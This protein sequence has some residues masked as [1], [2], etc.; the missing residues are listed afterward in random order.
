MHLRVCPKAA[1]NSPLQNLLDEDVQK[2]TV[3][4]LWAGKYQHVRSALQ[5]HLPVEMTISQQ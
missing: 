4:L 5:E 3:N 1:V 2:S